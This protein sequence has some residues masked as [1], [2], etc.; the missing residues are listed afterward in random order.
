[1]FSDLT[2]FIYLETKY[3]S[4]LVVVECQIRGKGIKSFSI[5][6][7]SDG[8]KHIDRA[9]RLIKFGWRFLD[10]IREI[11]GK[12]K[13]TKTLSLRAGTKDKLF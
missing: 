2:V 13:L 5:A 10:P 3:N 1:M 9:V 7:D 6:M 11:N 12:K 4:H 8:Q